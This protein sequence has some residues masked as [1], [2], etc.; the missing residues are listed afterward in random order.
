MPDFSFLDDDPPD[1]GTIRIRSTPKRRQ[2]LKR[3]P[4]VSDQFV[5]AS[6]HLLGCGC[7]LMALGLIMLLPMILLLALY[8]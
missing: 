1:D 7:S 4:T 5:E 3:A 2:A 6:N 8:H